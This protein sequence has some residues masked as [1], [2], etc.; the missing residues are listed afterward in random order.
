VG[1]HIRTPLKL[2]HVDPEYPPLA[3]AAHVGGR[4]VVECV[5]DTDGRVARARIVSGKPL[6]N[7]A[8]LAA[9]RQWLYRPT[10]L[11]GM[12][13]AVQMTVTVDFHLR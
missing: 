6:L 11:D 5:I 1:G 4:V 13:V 3:R 7:E 12:P 10:L 8:A 2:R 9:V